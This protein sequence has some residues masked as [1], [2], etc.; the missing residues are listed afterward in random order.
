MFH[1]NE[2]KPNVLPLAH[3]SED[4]RGM[5][6]NS[7][8]ALEAATL[9]SQ[10]QT[11]TKSSSSSFESKTSVASAQRSFTRFLWKKLSNRRR[12]CKKN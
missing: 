12:D 2:I 8:E 9:A 1:Q 10:S 7:A 11:T 3:T 6:S 4:V 5:L